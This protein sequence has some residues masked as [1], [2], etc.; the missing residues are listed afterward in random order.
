[1]NQGK[2][3]ISRKDSQFG[4]IRGIEAKEAFKVTEKWWSR[5]WKSK[6]ESKMKE[7]QWKVTHDCIVLND[8]LKEWELLMI[9]NV[10]FV[11]NTR[12]I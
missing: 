3:V 7:T 5:F 6:V 1:M 4:N 9:T 10:H 2:S 8:T 12:R 11:I